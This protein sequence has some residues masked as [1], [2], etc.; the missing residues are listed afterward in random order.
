MEADWGKDMESNGILRPT[1]NAASCRLSNIR[2]EIR[3]IQPPCT[4]SMHPT[5]VY[6]RV[7]TV[8]VITS[9]G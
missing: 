1:E 4:V 7:I 9:K 3:V 8:G 2:D 6:T 5:S